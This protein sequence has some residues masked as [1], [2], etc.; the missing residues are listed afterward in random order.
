MIDSTSV[1]EAF[2]Q[3]LCQTLGAFL[4]LSKQ[5]WSAPCGKVVS[6]VLQISFMTSYTVCSFICA[7]K[8]ELQIRWV[9]R[10]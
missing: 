10:H 1:S 4:N 9:D 5:Y 3:S 8:F 6:N 2:L 7:E